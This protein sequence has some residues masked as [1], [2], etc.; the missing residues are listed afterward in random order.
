MDKLAAYRVNQIAANS[1]NLFI[2]VR[3]KYPEDQSQ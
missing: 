2:L 1:N 3:I